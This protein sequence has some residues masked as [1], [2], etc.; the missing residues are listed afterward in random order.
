MCIYSNRR[1][2]VAHTHWASSYTNRKDLTKT[3]LSPHHKHHRFKPPEK[4]HNTS[5]FKGLGT[6]GDTCVRVC[7]GKFDHSATEPR[8][9]TISTALSSRLNYTICNINLKCDS[10]MQLVPFHKAC[11]HAGPN[12]KDGFAI[13]RGIKLFHSRFV[14]YIYIKWGGGGGGGD[15]KKKK[16]NKNK[17]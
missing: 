11:T 1:I 13:L 3:P 16:K 17:K 10:E 6:F 8:L 12:S 5:M 7:K 4:V 14:I 15:K 9:Y 2:L